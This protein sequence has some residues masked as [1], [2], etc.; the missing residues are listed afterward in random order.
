M[1][2]INITFPADSHRTKYSC[3]EIYSSF[4]VLSVV[5]LRDSLAE[6]V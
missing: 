5:L 3:T 4:C 6:F 2:F 1:Q